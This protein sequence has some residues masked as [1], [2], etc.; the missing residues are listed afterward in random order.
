MNNR[1]REKW[2]RM[3]MELMRKR[4]QAY[5]KQPETTSFMTIT[6]RKKAY[7]PHFLP[8]FIIASVTVCGFMSCLSKSLEHT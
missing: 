8:I 3:M 1:E 6:V 2:K 7:R 4:W 5:G